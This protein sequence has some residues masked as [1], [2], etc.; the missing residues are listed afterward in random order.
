MGDNQSKPSI[1][2][3]GKMMWRSSHTD[4][5]KGRRNTKK[6][7]DCSVKIPSREAG[8]CDCPDG[9]YYYDSGHEPITCSDAC[10]GYRPHQIDETRN[11]VAEWEALK[12][13]NR[14]TDIKSTARDQQNQKMIIFI[15]ILIGAYILFFRGNN[16]KT[17]KELYLERMKSDGII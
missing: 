16:K 15:L 17:A 9:P 6:D 14:E 8:Y 10:E 12:L 4:K 3:D 1:P 2:C 13:E 11:I 5:G 7:K